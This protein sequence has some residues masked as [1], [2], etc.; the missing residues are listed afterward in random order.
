MSHGTS[1][2]TKMLD[3]LIPTIPPFLDMMTAQADVLAK[4]MSALVDYLSEPSTAKFHLIMQLETQSRE[5]RD[6][7]MD[8]LYDAFSTPID[9]EDVL[10]SVLGLR[11]PVR[12]IRSLV[13]EMESLQ[14]KTD[15]FLL[16]MAEVVRESA[17]SL[18]VGY[19]KLD[20]APGTAD[21][22]AKLAI[23]C[24][25]NVDKI[26]GKGLVSV[27]N[28]DAHVNRLRTKETGAD[29]D[30]IVH[31]VEIITRREIYRHMQHLAEEITDVGMVLR[32]IVTKIA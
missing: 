14:I 22:D 23:K 31:V 30:A 21:G 4:G 16:E 6:L 25:E 24:S 29:A 26:N 20:T 12:K 28:I 17:L 2:F 32:R 7:H 8:I 15:R 11:V 19:A 27:C 10:Q 3:N 5:L 18:H 1:P 13:E 9:R